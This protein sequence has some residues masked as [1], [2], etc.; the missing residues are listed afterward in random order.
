M[1]FLIINAYSYHNA[2]DAAIMLSTRALLRDLGARRVRVSS[3]YADRESYRIHGVEPVEEILPYPERGVVA[4]AVRLL[5]L[6]LAT[7]GAL[8][9]IALARFSSRAARLSAAVFA[10]RAL[11]LVDEDTVIAIAGGGYMYSSRRKVNLGLLQCLVSIRLG[12]ALGAGT[13][14]L[15]QSIGPIHR[16][17]DAWLIRWSLRGTTPVARELVSV[18][19]ST[20]PLR[21][22][23]LTVVPDVAFYG[24]IC[25]TSHQEARRASQV[26]RI[27]VM[28][29]SWSSSV[30]S[31]AFDDYKHRVAE[32]AD[33]L[34]TRGWT[35][36]L[37]GHS[38]LP[39]HGQDDIAI[40][41]EI[42]QLM[43][44]PAAID[45][46]TSVAHLETA[47]RSV[48]IVIGTRLHSCI[49]ALTQGTPAVALAYQEKSRGVLKVAGLSALVQD[50]DSISVSA[51]VDL[52]DL[53]M[54]SDPAAR[55]K[56]AKA[57]IHRYYS[58]ALEGRISLAA[59]PAVTVG[60]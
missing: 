18:E 47:Y 28:D 59:H 60:A 12:R 58:A 26:A 9:V 39:D 25:E 57:T 32:F 11:R 53:A 49:M 51:L 29:W 27:V 56:E 35:V 55:A 6:L 17:F 50:V 5:T 3:R 19:A 7:V 38:S 42:A 52:V 37:G 2:G 44:S 45:A 34:A 13:V 15:P 10:R 24:S 22:P 14:M 23:A 21:L 20:T 31:G 30:S 43:T 40:A 1:D 48:G 36:V 41:R 54:Q 46:D 33:R 16:P 8:I 4:P